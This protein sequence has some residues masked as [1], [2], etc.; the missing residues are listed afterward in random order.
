M[1][2]GMTNYYIL[3]SPKDYMLDGTEPLQFR[4]SELVVCD[5]LRFSR[6]FCKAATYID[7]IEAYRHRNLLDDEDRLQFYPVRLSVVDFTRI[8]QYRVKQKAK[9]L[10]GLSRRTPIKIVA[11][12]YEEEGMDKEAAVLRWLISGEQYYASHDSLNSHDSLKYT[13]Q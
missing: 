9:E 12:R 11:D 1:A 3:I 7:V 2:V 13:P 5:D 6:V 10:F 8:V 4:R